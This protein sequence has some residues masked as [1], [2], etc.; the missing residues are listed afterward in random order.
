MDKIKLKKKVK[1]EVEDKLTWQP[2][3]GEITL[4]TKN[5]ASIYEVLEA[6]ERKLFYTAPSPN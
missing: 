2:I 5:L 4:F 3:T 1:K 6:F